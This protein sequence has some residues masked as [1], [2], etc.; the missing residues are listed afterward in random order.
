MEK[1]SGFRYTVALPLYI[2][3]KDDTGQD[4][5]VRGENNL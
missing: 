5:V 3:S 4:V 1:H 2:Q